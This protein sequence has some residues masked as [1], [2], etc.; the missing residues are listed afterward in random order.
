MDEHRDILLAG[1]RRCLHDFRKSPW[2]VAR[3]AG[4]GSARSYPASMHDRPDC[5][6]A[7]SGALPDA[8]LLRGSGQARGQRLSRRI[9]A[10]HRCD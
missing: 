3:H 7:D 5:D 8:I 1:M 9:H 10:C 6:A 4:Q 2:I